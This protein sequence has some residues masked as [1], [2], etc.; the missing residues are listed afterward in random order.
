MPQYVPTDADVQTAATRLREAAATRTACPPV[1][2]LIG[3]DDVGTAY[4]VQRLINDR[5]IRD[6]GIVT[7]RKIGLTSRAVQ[8]QL[9]VDRPD[10]GVLFADMGYANDSILPM[11][12]LL[13]PRVEAEVAFVLN[14]D[15]VDGAL[16]TDD[17]AGAV[18]YAVA[19]LEIVDSR[20][21]GW[22]ITFADTVADNGS[23]G[24]YVLGEE[25]VSLD[26]FVPSHC[27]MR[28]M[29]D[30]A[31]VS[32]GTGSACLGDPIA[33]LS[34]LA[35]F[36]REVGQPLRAGEVILSGALGPMVPVVAGAH[37]VAEISGLGTVACQFE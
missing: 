21:E 7:G 29:V 3:R 19:A 11:D 23:S 1:R 12:L 31:E 27:E 35:Q 4:A 14:N 33:A 24:L 22:D 18:N 25:R 8:E 20:I 28:M 37:A 32:T 17:V 15:L 5:R 34:W 10:F 13:A 26:V 36:A 6:G 30:G 16:G 2:D 9:G